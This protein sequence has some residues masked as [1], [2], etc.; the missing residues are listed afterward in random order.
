MEKLIRDKVADIPHPSYPNM[1]TRKVKD[2]VEHVS[3]L[4]QK[5][6]EEYDEFRITHNK[7]EKIAEAGDVFECF[8]ALEK[9]SQKDKD[10]MV[11][12]TITREQ[13]IQECL[14]ESLDIDEIY[15]TQHKKQ[16]KRGGFDGGIIWIS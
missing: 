11:K 9:I 2:L 12:Y 1:R 8:D 4:L 7:M 15:Q 14:K 16:E 10:L 3:F 6:I 5:I 13:F